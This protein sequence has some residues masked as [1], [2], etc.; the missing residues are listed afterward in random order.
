MRLHP[1]HHII[2]IPIHHIIEAQ[3]CMATLVITM[4]MIEEGDLTVI[5]STLIEA[6][7]TPIKDRVDYLLQVLLVVPVAAYIIQII[8]HQAMEVIILHQAT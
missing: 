3:A 2:Q 1:I 8:I 4:A 7:V 5:E 6:A